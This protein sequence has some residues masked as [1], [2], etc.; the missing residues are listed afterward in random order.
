M[1]LNNFKLLTST[2]HGRFQCIGDTA[3]TSTILS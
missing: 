2:A 1:D 3:V